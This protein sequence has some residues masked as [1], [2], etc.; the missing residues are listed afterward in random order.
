ML[1]KRLYQERPPRHEYRLTE[2]GLDLWPTIVALMSWGD[3]YAP[4]AGRP[5]RPARAP[6]LRRQRSTSTASARDCGARV[7]AR[8]CTGA[9]GHRGRLPPKRSRCCAGARGRRRSDQR[10][11]LAGHARARHD[12]VEAGLLSARSRAARRRG[13]RSRASARRAI[14]GS[15]ASDS[16]MPAPSSAGSVRSTTSTHGR[17]ARA[18]RSPL[19]Q[20]LSV[21][22]QLDLV[23]GAGERALHARAE[24]QVGAQHEHPRH[25]YWA[26]RRR[27][28]SRADWGRPHI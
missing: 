4:P 1:E 28:S 14:P 21:G 11:A 15:P 17:P 6:R 12:Q 16:T 5:A 10:G 23:P 24:Q 20:T 9:A 2:K 26:R 19:A 8:E 3:R 22:D 25:R 13:S 18:S 27:N 7:T